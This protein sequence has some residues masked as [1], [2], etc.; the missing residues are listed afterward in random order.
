MKNKINY[1]LTNTI[2]SLAD[3]FCVF[4]LAVDIL[5]VACVYLP[6]IRC[7]MRNNMD[8]VFTLQSDT[9]SCH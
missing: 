9:Y 7:P 3:A 4:D 6:P 1:K 2:T 8:K 5:T